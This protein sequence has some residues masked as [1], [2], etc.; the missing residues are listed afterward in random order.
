MLVRHIRPPWP[1]E[2]RE[3]RKKKGEKKKKREGEKEEKR[4]GEVR[5]NKSPIDVLAIGA[6]MHTALCM[7]AFCTGMM[8]AK[9]TEFG[10]MCQKSKMVIKPFNVAIVSTLLWFRRLFCITHLP[11]LTWMGFTWQFC[12]A[13]LV[14]SMVSP[15]KETVIDLVLQT[16]NTFFTTSW[17]T[18]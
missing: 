8:S 14:L 1:R 7:R 11:F 18:N 13:T 15:K 5:P 6:P 2:K 10:K 4:G 17:L 16:K 12:T 3:K 9:R